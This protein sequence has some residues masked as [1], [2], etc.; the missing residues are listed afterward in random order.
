NSATML[1]FVSANKTT[2]AANAILLQY[3][4]PIITILI[5]TFFL[6]EHPKIEHILAIPL[7]AMG[8]ILMFIDDL[9]G[10]HLLGNTLALLSAF[11]FSLYFIFM[12]KQKYGSPLESIL[13]SHWFTACIAL[14]V[15]FFIPLPSV[16][17]QSIGAIA[18]LGVVQIGFAAI[19]FSA[20]IKKVSAAQ[21]NLIAVIEPVFNPIWVFL[22]LGETPGIR[23]LIGGIIVIA[24]VT[25]SSVINTIRAK[26]DVVK[27]SSAAD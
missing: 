3:F 19:L 4:A 5:G 8:L 7:V 22:V 26:A 2:T 23:T 25:A 14:I 6:K 12:R 13:L 16:S 15:S 24:A 17:W 1:L 27:A 10:G 20:A 11:S 18:V 9:S 21:A